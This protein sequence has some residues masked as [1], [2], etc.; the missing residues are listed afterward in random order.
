MNTAEQRALAT[1]V[2][3]LVS[4]VGPGAVASPGDDWSQALVAAEL[5]GIGTPESRGGTGGD[6][7]DALVVV[8]ALAAAAVSWPGTADT[9]VVTRL[10]D[11]WPSVTVR[12]GDVPVVPAGRSQLPRLS[13]S[14]GEWRLDGFVAAVPGAAQADRLV[15]L[16]RDEGGHVRVALVRPAE[17]SVVAGQN[18]AG[19]PRDDVR[20]GIRL[21]D[22]SVSP[23]LA[24]GVWDEARGLAALVAAAAI[25]GALEQT[26]T[27]T[28]G[29]VRDREQF[30]RPLAEFQAVQQHLAEIAEQVAAARAAVAAATRA[31]DPA[32]YGAAKARASEAAG[33]VA[34]LAH[35]LHGAMGTSREYPLGHLTTRLWSWTQDAGTAREWHRELGHALLAGSRDLWTTVIDRSP[36]VP[37]APP[38]PLPQDERG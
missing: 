33:V 10:L 22:G 18:L 15:V 35:Q 20:L 4:A 7:A 38:E 11:G 17:A 26:L 36:P 19:E 1:S 21:D 2:R 37:L 6:T 34:R 25:A 3:G 23:A 16:A 12:V 32:S 29:Y 30:G 27:L 24:P 31:A 5:H 13:G 28:L 8:S 14:D 9:L